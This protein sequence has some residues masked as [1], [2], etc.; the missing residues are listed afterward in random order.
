[1]KLFK[2]SLLSLK[3]S[4]AFDCGFAYNNQIAYSVFCSVVQEWYQLAEFHCVLPSFSIAA[5]VAFLTAFQVLFVSRL[6]IR[7]TADQFYGTTF[8]IILW[9]FWRN[10]QSRISV[11]DIYCTQLYLYNVCLQLTLIVFHFRWLIAYELLG[12]IELANCSNPFLYVI[13][14]RVIFDGFWNWMI[15]NSNEWHAAFAS[16][17]T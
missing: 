7:R 16:E 4:I 9:W 17:M 5:D 15:S 12:W 2:I 10:I 3:W 8:I 11:S 13:S 6:R 14:Y 1:M